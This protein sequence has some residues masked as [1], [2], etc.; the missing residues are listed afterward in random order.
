MLAQR[1]SQFRPSRAWPRAA[2]RT[3]Q[4]GRV[5]R[6]LRCPFLRCPKLRWPRAAR[7]AALAAGRVREVLAAGRTGHSGRV[8]WCLRCRFEAQLRWPRAARVAALAAGRMR[9]V[10]ALGR[11]ELSDRVIW[12]L[13]CRFGSLL[14]S[15]SG[16]LAR[17]FPKISQTRA[18]L[19]K[20]FVDSSSTFDIFR[21][22]A[23]SDCATHPL[24]NASSRRLDTYVAQL[25]LPHACVC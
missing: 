23:R 16:R 25:T 13:W 11:I 18:A 17:H 14:Q 12:C 2:G 22:L 3:G 8:A 4:S 9:E 5:A 21:R 15:I 7:V 6:C 19:S 10:L 24:T 20:T 1:K